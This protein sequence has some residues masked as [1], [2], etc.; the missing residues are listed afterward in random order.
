MLFSLDL[1]PFLSSSPIFQLQNFCQD[2]YWWQ[3][4]LFGDG[5]WYTNQSIHA[6]TEGEDAGDG[7]IFKGPIHL[8]HLRQ[9][10]TTQMHSTHFPPHSTHLWFAPC[11]C[12]YVAGETITISTLTTIIM[13]R[14]FNCFAAV[15]LS[16]IV[17]HAND[18]VMEAQLSDKLDVSS[19][20]NLLINAEFFRSVQLVKIHPIQKWKN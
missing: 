2:I 6:L 10:Q 4:W 9:T 5:S 3:N 1:W 13:I 18:P 19:T 16:L 8:H 14:C 11:Q 20:F 15:S 12:V 17:K 7:N